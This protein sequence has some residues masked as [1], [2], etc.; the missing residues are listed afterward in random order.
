MLG[1]RGHCL[2]LTR[3]SAG[4]P[5][6]PMAVCNAA[7]RVYFSTDWPETGIDQLGDGVTVEA[8]AALL[9]LAE[10]LLKAAAGFVL[11]LGKL[12]PVGGVR[13]EA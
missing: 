7:G 4:L 2:E 9:A 6:A 3:R 1:I 8:G 5:I 10:P 13:T 12:R 11:V